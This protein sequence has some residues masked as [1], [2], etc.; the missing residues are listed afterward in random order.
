MIEQDKIYALVIWY[1]PTLKNVRNTNSYINNVNKLIIIDNSDEDNSSFLADSDLS[2]II[3]IANKEN[4]GIASELNHGCKL[5]IELGAEWVLTMDQDSCFHEN[6]LHNFIQSANEYI[7]FEK[8][9][10]FAAFHFD[11][12]YKNQKPVFENKYSKMNYTMTSGNILSLQKL[13]TI[14]FFLDDLF[15]D[16]VDEE[17]CIRTRKLNLQIVQIND[18]AMEHFVGNGIEKIN[19]F[20]KPKYY[21]NYTPIRYY[22]ITRNI[23]IICK[24]HPADAARLK[25]RWK[26]LVRKTL[27]YDKHNKIQKLKYIILGI[28]DSIFGKKGS[29]KRKKNSNLHE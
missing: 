11:S 16:W 6:N 1:Y 13:Q 24:L 8:V 3:Y 4:K 22:Y 23:F 19:F 7:D 27:L 21:H 20:G 17:F 9:A 12:R 28:I 18:I 29:F 14:G 25:K 5:A 2:K 15:I 26:K 10:I